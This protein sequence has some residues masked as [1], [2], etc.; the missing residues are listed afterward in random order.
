MFEFATLGRGLGCLLKL[1]VNVTF[2]FRVDFFGFNGRGGK[3][4]ISTY[5][6]SYYGGSSMVYLL[7][8]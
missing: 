8:D 6:L 3:F 5:V 2:F 1:S 7:K 4:K